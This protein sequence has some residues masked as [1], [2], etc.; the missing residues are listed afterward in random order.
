MYTGVVVMPEDE[1]EEW[2]SD[3]TAMAPVIAADATPADQGFQ[4][5]LRN[6]CNACHSSD[7]SKL[8]GP[9]YLGFWG[10]MRKVTAGGDKTEVMMDEDYVRRSIYD[11]NAEI[12][13]G[14]N[15]GLMLSYEGL[16]SEEE[17]D[18]IIEYIKELNE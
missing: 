8:V 14:Y 15:K 7:G 9:S 2:I 11:P 5:L 6:G 10:K 13:D 18:L 3:T 12:A 16:V 1:F 4:V 17:I